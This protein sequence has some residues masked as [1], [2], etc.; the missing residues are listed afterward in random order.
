MRKMETEIQ[1][2]CII[3]MGSL[4]TNI[5]KSGRISTTVL[6]KMRKIKQ[7]AHEKGK[8]CS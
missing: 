8:H 4:S 3:G 2:S 1:C 5:I 6:I 7:K